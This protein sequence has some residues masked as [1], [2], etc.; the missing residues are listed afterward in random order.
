LQEWR[1]LG[2]P[3]G[4]FGDLDR[5]A[6]SIGVKRKCEL[7]AGTITGLDMPRGSTWLVIADS[8]W[9]L[10]AAAADRFIDVYVG[11]A[12]SSEC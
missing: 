12:P 9:S 8:V 5:C 6:G 1:F 11:R 2:D 10:I 4:S 7:V 3:G